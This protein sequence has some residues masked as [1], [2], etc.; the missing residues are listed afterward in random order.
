[1]AF[2]V[3]KPFRKPIY[4]NMPFFFCVLFIFVFNTCVVFLPSSSSVSSLFD[5]QPFVTE[6]G[7]EY[8]RYR[9]WVAL[10]IALNSVLTILAEQLI[11]KFVTRAADSNKQLRKE[12]AFH[13]AMDGYRVQVSDF[14]SILTEPDDEVIAEVSDKRERVL[15]SGKGVSEAVDVI[16]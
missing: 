7:K 10:G 15:L 14:A 3:A 6:G 12:A 2:S 11:V 16:R 8:Y 13:A 5:L 9:F 4:S 1:M